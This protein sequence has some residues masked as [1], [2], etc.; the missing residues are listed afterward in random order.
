MR[1]AGGTVE[2][3][4]LRGLAK[5]SDVGQR[6]DQAQR[7]WDPLVLVDGDR[8]LF[9]LDHSLGDCTDGSCRNDQNDL[10]GGVKQPRDIAS[11]SDQ[12]G[13]PGRS[14]IAQYIGDHPGVL[15][16]LGSRVIV[17]PGPSSY[18]N[19]L[20]E[21]FYGTIKQEEIYLVGNYPDEISA[22]EEIGRYIE[23]YHH[24]RPHQSLMNFTPAH[25]HVV[26]NKSRLLAELQ[27]MK[28]KTREKRKAYWVQNRNPGATPS[29]GKCPD[30]GQDRSVAPGANTAA[31][32]QHQPPESQNE[33]RELLTC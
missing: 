3:P 6:L 30:K 29:D 25:V 5:K 13:T 7:G 18:D 22:R 24:S 21:R 28:R 2:E 4:A 1:E 8:F 33:N 32:S 26:N 15:R 16:R 12:A 31:V 17:C 23:R 19:A 14:G 10:P 9:A 11:Q 20:T 27:A